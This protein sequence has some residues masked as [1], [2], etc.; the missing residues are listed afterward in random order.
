[1]PRLPRRS[2][3]PPVADLARDGQ[4]LL[5]VLDG[6]PR[7]PQ[8]RVG[9]AQV[10]QVVPLARAGRRSP[11]RWPAPARSTRWPAAPRPGPRR[12]S[13]GCPGRSPPRAG[14]RS[15]AR[16]PAPA[17]STRWPAAPPPGRVGI[18][19]VAQVGALPAPVADLPRDGQRLLVVLDGPPRLPQG[20]VGQCP[21]CPGALPSAPL[22][23]Q[24]PRRASRRLQPGDPLPR[25]QPQVQE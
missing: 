25:V 20:R 6:P 7:L 8:V 13:P 9:H 12:R 19:Q 17:R 23:P 1:M 15:P 22:V 14:R 4:R 11:A 16:W 10:A 3:R 5:V 2:P 24:P 18:P 21:G